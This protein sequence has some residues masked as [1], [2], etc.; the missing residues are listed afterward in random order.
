MNFLPKNEK[1]N[2]FEIKTLYQYDIREDYDELNDKRRGK[3]M[4]TCNDNIAMVVE[5]GIDGTY[6]TYTKF[7]VWEKR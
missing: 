7:E 5:K 6:P 1:W 4:A 2:C 3:T